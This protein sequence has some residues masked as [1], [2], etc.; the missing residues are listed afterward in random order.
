M[1]ERKLFLSLAALMFAAAAATAE[2]GK[3]QPFTIADGQLRMVAPENWKTMKPAT[4]IVEHEFAVP[5]SEGDEQPGRLTVMGAGGSVDAN[6]ERWYGQF[7]QPDGSS[8]KDKA[9]VSKI[10]V[11][12]EEVHLVDISG[13]FKDQKGP[14]APAVERE[15]YRMLGAILV[16]KKQGN[17]FIKLTGPR[18]T[19]GDNEE[20]FDKLVKSLEHK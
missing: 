17:Y 3:P 18:R 4:N 9:K 8:T 16:T 5:A 10:T 15:K 2:E 11:A 6:I 13:T 12:G 7:S 1:I 19:V 14:F 20:G